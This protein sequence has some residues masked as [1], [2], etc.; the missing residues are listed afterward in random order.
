MK[1][2]GCGL[3]VIFFI[4]FRGVSGLGRREGGNCRRIDRIF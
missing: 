1:E 3:L 4:A 2:E